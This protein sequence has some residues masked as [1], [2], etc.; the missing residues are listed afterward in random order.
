MLKKGKQRFKK[1]IDKSGKHF[2]GNELNHKI[3]VVY[4]LEHQKQ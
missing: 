3:D 1:I 2:K 4:D